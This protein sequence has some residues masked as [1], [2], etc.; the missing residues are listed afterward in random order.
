MLQ[1]LMLCA[2]PVGPHVWTRSRRHA[3]YFSK[4]CPTSFLSHSN[5]NPGQN[6][7]ASPSRF[8]SSSAL[9][10]TSAASCPSVA[11]ESLG[12][13]A[14]PAAAMPVLLSSWPW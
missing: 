12:S 2:P 13:A 5:K 1:L 4:H 7:A 9:L 14:A 11:C 8:D 6:P 10:R 3:L